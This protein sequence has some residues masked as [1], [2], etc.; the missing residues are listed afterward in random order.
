VIRDFRADDQDRYRWVSEFLL[1]VLGEQAIFQSVDIGLKFPR[2]LGEGMQGEYHA[3][4][5]VF[6]GTGFAALAFLNPQHLFALAVVLFDFPADPT[7]VLHNDGGIL[8]QVV[9]GDM[10]S[11]ENAGVKIGHI[12]LGIVRE[13][14]D[15][16]LAI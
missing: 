1:H 3:A 15:E 5:V 4:N 8:G 14:R 12:R 2:P 6:L 13:G 9:G 16:E 11:C 7:Q 10:A